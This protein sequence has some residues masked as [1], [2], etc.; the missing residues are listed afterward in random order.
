MLS[1]QVKKSS[2]VVR[3]PYFL[4]NRPSAKDPVVEAKVVPGRKAFSLPQ[5]V[6]VLC[7]DLDL[8]QREDRLGFGMNAGYGL[9][10]LKIFFSNWN[11][12][13]RSPGQAN[14]KRI[15]PGRGE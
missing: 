8:L 13:S 1:S 14:T 12:S 3:R 9:V 11:A 2:P 15:L 4:R 10:V 7:D 5:C 6:A